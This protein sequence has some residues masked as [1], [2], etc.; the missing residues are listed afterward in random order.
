MSAAIEEAFRR[1]AARVAIVGTDA[2]FV[3]RMVVLEAFRALEDR[4]LVI[5]PALDGG[6]CLLALRRPQ[7]AIFQGIAWS[8]AS[9][10]PATL[11]RA[12]TLGLS[13]WLLEPL[14]DIDT[15]EDV[16]T[17]WARLAPLLDRVPGLTAAVKAALAGAPRLTAPEDGA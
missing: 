12:G 14:P 17:Q 10:L 8:T 15:L 13:T 2:P 1:G 6:Y 3:S 9:V 11:E 7:P 5:G 16:R 4:D